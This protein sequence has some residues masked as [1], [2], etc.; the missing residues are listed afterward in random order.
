MLVMK[1]KLI[2]IGNSKGVRLPRLVIEECGFGE[3][4]ERRVELGSVVLARARGTREGWD[5]AFQKMAANRDDTL[6][7][8]DSLDHESNAAEWKR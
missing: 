6:R 2:P 8:P 4:I 5:A 7:I 3:Q 1:V